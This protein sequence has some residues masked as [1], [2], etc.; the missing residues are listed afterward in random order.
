MSACLRKVSNGLG[1]VSDG[2]EKVSNGFKKI[3]YGLCKVLDDLVKVSV[4][5]SLYTPAAR[6]HIKIIYCELQL[7]NS[8]KDCRN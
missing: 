8:L 3:S 5:Q 7:F 2:L 1:K 6:W 4:G